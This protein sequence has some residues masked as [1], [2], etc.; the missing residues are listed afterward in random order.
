MLVITN[1]IV[2]LGVDIND[3]KKAAIAGLVNAVVIVGFLAHDA[4]VRHGRAQLAA[5][6]AINHGVTQA[7]RR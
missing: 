7:A 4:I 1:L 5:A 3:T 6:R 2:L